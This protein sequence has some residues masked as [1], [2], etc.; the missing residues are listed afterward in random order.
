MAIIFVSL[1][2][3]FN[4]PPFTGIFIPHVVDHLFSRMI[5]V[6]LLNREVQQWPRT[7]PNYY[8]FRGTKINRPKPGRCPWF[9]G[10]GTNSFSKHLTTILT[11]ATRRYFRRGTARRNWVSLAAWHEKPRFSYFFY[12]Y[13]DDWTNFWPWR[14]L[15]KRHVLSSWIYFPEEIRLGSPFKMAEPNISRKGFGYLTK[16]LALKFFWF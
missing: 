14:K 10:V 13:R 1:S 2:C 16:N 3:I 5:D 8:F 4:E 12:W 15:K 9:V 7:L 6:V 11:R